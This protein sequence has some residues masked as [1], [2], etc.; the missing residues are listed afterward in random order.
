ML[1]DYHL[2]NHFSPDSNADTAELI[3]AE[4]KH[5]VQEICLTN[6][7]E[8]FDKESK[9]GIGIFDLEEAV[10]RFESVEWE[11]ENLQNK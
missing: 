8:W 5:G 1:I 7:A 11:I 9:S 3:E 6:H 10:R 4:K 2:H